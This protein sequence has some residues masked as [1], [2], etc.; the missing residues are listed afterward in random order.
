MPFPV[1]FCYWAPVTFRKGF[2]LVPREQW[3]QVKVGGGYREKT[4]ARW[5]LEGMGSAGL[6]TT[7]KLVGSPPRL[8]KMAY[9]QACSHLHQSEVPVASQQFKISIHPGGS[10]IE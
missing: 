10:V 8:L 1:L 2:L 4:Q 7:I 5:S 6:V 3:R 9:I